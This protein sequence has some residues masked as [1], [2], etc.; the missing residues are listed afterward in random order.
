MNPKSVEF[1]RDYNDWR[2]DSGRYDGDNMASIP[3]MPDTKEVGEAIDWACEQIAR[4]KARDSEWDQFA[5]A[6]GKHVGCLASSFP[7]ANDHIL[8]N[9][10][11]LRAQ[12][13]ELLAACQT[14]HEWLR[15]EEE[16]FVKAG[17][18]RDT[19]QG[20]AAWRAW[21]DEN[22]RLCDLAQ[23]QARDAIEN[24]TKDTTA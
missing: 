11:R 13:D 5:L 15:R 3:P 21:Y 16:G 8:R 2:R 22:M 4:L 20:E 10:A 19:P 23:K 6:V 17:N 7:D 1:L 9:I 12:R 18:S 24:T 14:F